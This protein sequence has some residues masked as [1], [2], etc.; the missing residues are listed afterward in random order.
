MTDPASPSQPHLWTTIV[1]GGRLRQLRRE[2]AL[3]QERLADRAGIS[4]ATV[5]RLERQH[6]APCRS[7]TLARLAAA[8][9]TEP[10]TLTPARRAERHAPRRATAH[11]PRDQA[12]KDS[13]KKTITN[14]PAH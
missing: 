1:D 14:G 13:V 12:T 8:L 5:A 7:R 11:D 2:A 10:A 3:S 9:H 6:H 4:P